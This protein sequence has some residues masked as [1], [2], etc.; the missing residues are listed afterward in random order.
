MPIFC[1]VFGFLIIALKN[2]LK[3]LTH[4]AEDNEG[5]Q[6]EEAEPFELGDDQEPDEIV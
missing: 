4:G 5:T 6:H 3:S 2:K 1:A